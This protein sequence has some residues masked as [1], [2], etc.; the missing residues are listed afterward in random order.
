MKW[1]FRNIVIQTLEYISKSLAVIIGAGFLHY[2]KVQC[3]VFMVKKCQF[4]TPI[5]VVN[6]YQL[7]S[8]QG[9]LD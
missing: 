7:D 2:N 5:K 1:P 8:S 6:H 3:C 4:F 9:S